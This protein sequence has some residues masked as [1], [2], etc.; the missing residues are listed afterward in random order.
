MRVGV[1]VRDCV[2][3]AGQTDVVGSRGDHFVAGGDPAHDFDAGTVCRTDTD[4]LF[5]VVA[6]RGADIEVV[7]ALLFGERG[8]RYGQNVVA[9]GSFQ[10]HFDTSKNDKAINIKCYRKN[11]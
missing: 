1:A 8:E 3:H 11:D 9:G 4:G 5:Q 10:E 7:G 2:G 6:G